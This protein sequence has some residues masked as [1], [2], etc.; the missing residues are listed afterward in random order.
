MKLINRNRSNTSFCFCDSFLMGRK[1]SL[2]FLILSNNA[3]TNQLLFNFVNLTT[4]VPKELKHRS[5]LNLDGA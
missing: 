5:E 2:K 1:S 4:L 3:S